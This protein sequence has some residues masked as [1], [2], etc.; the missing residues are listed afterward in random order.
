MKTFKKY[1]ELLEMAMNQLGFIERYANDIFKDVNVKVNITKGHFFDRI[2]D[3]RNGKPIEK[4]EVKDLFK[5][6]YAK[7][8][9]QIGALPAKEEF[10]I[11]DKASEINIP[12]VVDKNHKIS[13]KT[14]MRKKN[15]LT[16][17]IRYV[18]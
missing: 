15:F 8:G 3:K 4:D 16:R 2:N 17:T 7:Y 18:V 14:I 5:K 10:V 1:L 6:A 13:T 11:F 9:E 12:F